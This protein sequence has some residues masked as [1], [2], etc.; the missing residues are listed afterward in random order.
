MVSK[1][2]G[3]GK[4]GANVSFD[5]L[6]AALNYPLIPLKLLFFH[7]V[8]E[9]L[10]NFVVVFQTDKSTTPFLAEAEVLLRWLMLN[11]IRKNVLEKASTFGA[12]IKIDPCEKK[13]PEAN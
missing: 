5:R 4:P 9:K 13:Q 3:S 12:L 6:C 10:C 8:A 7:E 11:F 2:P 1:Q